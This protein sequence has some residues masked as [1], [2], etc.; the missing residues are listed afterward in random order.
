[1]GK[2]YGYVRVSSKDQNIRRQLDAIRPWVKTEQDIH[3]DKQSGKD[4]NRPQ[5]QALKTLL[6][7]GDVLVIQSL[8]RLGRNYT[9]I[10]DE[11]R[12]LGEKGVGI[13]VLD[14]PALNTVLEH[15]K[16]HSLFSLFIC[17]VVLE[18]LSFVAENER[19][20]IRTRQ[21]QGIASAKQRGVKF[22]R[23]VVCPDSF[24]PAYCNWKAGRISSRDAIEQSGMKKSTFYK[25]V[26]EFEKVITEV[27]KGTMTDAQAAACDTLMVQFAVQ[28]VN[29][30][31]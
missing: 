6:A 11:W 9:Q 29:F 25:R 13:R 10:K 3:I 5:Y 26:R 2:V 24:F 28:I 7:A 16:D 30:G 27:G 20:N 14:F 8:D 15:G 22:G 31:V 23:D 19:N 1:M 4:F 12:E 17:N 21:A 18:V